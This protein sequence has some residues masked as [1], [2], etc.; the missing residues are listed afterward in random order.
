MR[1]E[2]WNA[3]LWQEFLSLYPNKTLVF[4]REEVQTLVRKK[5]VKNFM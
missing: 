3:N 5:I 2:N 1:N 4:M